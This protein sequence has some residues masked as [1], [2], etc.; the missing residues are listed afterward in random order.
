MDMKNIKLKTLLNE[1]GF[2]QN[3]TKDEWEVIA[4]SVSLTEGELSGKSKKDAQKILGALQGKKI[5]G[6]IE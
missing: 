2:S 6:Q 5:W 4:Y 3:F 1:G